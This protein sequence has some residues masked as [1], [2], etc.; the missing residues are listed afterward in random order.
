[1]LVDV[2]VALSY[3]CAFRATAEFTELVA[4]LLVCA[5]PKVEA[6]SE[7]LFGN[8][9]LFVAAGLAHKDK[10]IAHVDAMRK[11]LVPERHCERYATSILEK[12]TFADLD[13]D[14]RHLAA[15]ALIDWHRYG[16]STV[17]MIADL[18]LAMVVDSDPAV[19]HCPLSALAAAAAQCLF[20]SDY[21]SL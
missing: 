7:I 2:V 9:R 11:C 13:N 8:Q 5:A 20:A 3:L 12:L 19:S 1:L 10:V 6:P 14:V 15:F 17:K 21:S 16:K 18:Y 4:C